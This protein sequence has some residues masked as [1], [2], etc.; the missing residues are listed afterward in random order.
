M[1]AH[2]VP[3]DP[4]ELRLD[5]YAYEV[6][7]E[8]GS[9]CHAKRAAKAGHLR[10][11]GGPVSPAHWVRAGEELSLE[12]PQTARAPV[13]DLP[14]EICYQDDWLAV[15]NKPA[16]LFTSGNMHRTL[17]H[18]LPA[19]LPRSPL[20]DAL[21]AP[22][23]VHRLDGRTAGAVV[24]ARTAGARAALGQAFAGREVEK[25]YLAFAAGRLE[26]EGIIDAPVGGRPARTRWKVVEHIRSLHIDWMSRVHLWPETG[27]THQIRVHLAGLGHPVLGDDLYTPPGQRLLVGQGMFLAAVAVAF[28]HPATGARLEVEVPP[29]LRFERFP[30]R[31]AR[32][33]DRV[34]AA[35]ITSG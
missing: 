20:P 34:Q 28:D 35:R 32:R 3:E 29:P 24:V 5:R 1:P 9:R 18:A 33:W 4:P 26:G 10:M 25:R 12:L 31:E 21:A 17:A 15:V 6:F 2:T 11:N 14:I 22:W 13:A 7:P 16:G 19:I 8:L 23:P 27:R 30:A